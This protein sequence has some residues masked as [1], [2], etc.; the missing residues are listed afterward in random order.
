MKSESSNESRV[1][2]EQAIIKA[3]FKGKCRNF[4]VLGHKSVHCKSRRNHGNRQS[5]AN[6]Q[7]PYCVYCRKT[8]HVKVD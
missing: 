3:K 8:G 5:D 6:F 2:E 1:N 7:P 4:G